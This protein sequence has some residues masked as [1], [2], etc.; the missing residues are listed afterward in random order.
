MIPIS[1][2][3]NFPEVARAM[4]EL[5]E[6]VGRQAMVRALNRTMDQGKTAMARQISGEY[7]ITVGEARKRLVIHRARARRGQVR[8]EAILEGTGSGK[9]R[10]MNV[11]AFVAAAGNLGSKSARQRQIRF[12]IRRSGDMKTIPGAFIGNQGRTVFIRSPGATTRKVG[13]PWGWS[14]LPIEPVNTIGIPQMFNARKIT[15][16]VRRLML[17]KFPE[18][19]AREARYYLGQWNAR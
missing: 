16:A 17:E 3:T 15:E 14:G 18:V 13:R 7:V 2:R 10:S 6:K 12:K 11:I 9:G 5:P 8:F 1:L 19:F 4:R